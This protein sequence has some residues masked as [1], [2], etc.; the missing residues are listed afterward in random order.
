MSKVRSFTLLNLERMPFV[1]AWA[2][3]AFSVSPMPSLELEVRFRYSELVLLVVSP[4]RF[5]E[6]RWCSVFL[7]LRPG[8][9]MLND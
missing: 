2:M 3:P 9:R 7:K 8:V 6:S 4:T 5:A 1:R